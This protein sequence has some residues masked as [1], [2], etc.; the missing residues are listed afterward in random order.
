[1]DIT[2]RSNARPRGDRRGLAWEPL[3]LR[4]LV[5]GGFIDPTQNRS[6]ALQIS[7]PRR[8]AALRLRNVKLRI[9]TMAIASIANGLSPLAFFRN[10]VSGVRADELRGGPLDKRG[11]GALI[12]DQRGELVSA[13]LDRLD[14]FA[15]DFR[16]PDDGG[17]E[18]GLGLSQL[19]TMM[20]A[21]FARAVGARRQIDRRINGRGSGLFFWV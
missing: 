20:D 5:A 11:A 13:E 17:T 16:R 4:A 3:P 18:R 14:S 15:A 21:N 2:S 1:M 6:P 10:L 19:R 7:S 9:A 12:L 8:T